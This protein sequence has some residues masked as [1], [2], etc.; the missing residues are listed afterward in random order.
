MMDAGV[1]GFHL[2]TSGDGVRTS[3]DLDFQVLMKS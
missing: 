3:G 1:P 2:H